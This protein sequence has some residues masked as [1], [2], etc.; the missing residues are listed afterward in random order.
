MIQATIS[1][2]NILARI[3]ATITAS[4]GLQNFLSE[5]IIRNIFPSLSEFQQFYLQLYYTTSY[6]KSQVFFLFFGGCLNLYLKMFD[7]TG[8]NT[9]IYGQASKY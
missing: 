6:W 9:I 1:E 5:Y 4:R 7:R 8:P 2:A 3:I